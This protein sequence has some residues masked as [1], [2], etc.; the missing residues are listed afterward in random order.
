MMRRRDD[1]AAAKMLGLFRQNKDK[2]SYRAKRLKAFSKRC[3]TDKSHFYITH[4]DAGGNIIMNGG[5]FC[6]VD[7]DD[8][9]LAP[10]ERDAWFCLHWDWAMETFREALRQ[11]GIDYMLRPERLAYYCYYMFFYYLNEFIK[12]YFEIGNRGGDIYENLRDYLSC[13]IEEN[14]RFADNMLI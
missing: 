7:W 1:E 2:I 11:S 4:G 6:I 10:P 13:W 12:T 8:P 3:M 9:V 14:I 5:K